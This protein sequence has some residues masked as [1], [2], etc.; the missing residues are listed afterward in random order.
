MYSLRE[1]KLS[2][3]SAPENLQADIVAGLTV[4][5][6]AVPQVVSFAAMAGLPAQFGLYGCFAPVIGLCFLRRIPSSVLSFPRL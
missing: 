2:K 1:M 6:M 4:G 3:S 5:V